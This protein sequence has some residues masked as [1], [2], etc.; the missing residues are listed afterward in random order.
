LD[1]VF[2]FTEHAVLVCTNTQSTQT[3]TV[4]TM[5]GNTYKQTFKHSPLKSIVFFCQ[6]FLVGN[7][8]V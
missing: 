6:A 5:F 1:S 4:I 7:R 3:H 8:N 2:G